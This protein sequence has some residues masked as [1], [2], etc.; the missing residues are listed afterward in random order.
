[1]ISN[2]T[3]AAFCVDVGLYNYFRHA[4][5]EVGAAISA[6]MHKIEKAKRDEYA[7]AEQDG[8]LPGQYWLNTN[9]PKVRSADLVVVL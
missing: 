8:R 9:P 1:M 7:S 4:S 5:P 3:L 6:Y 2:E